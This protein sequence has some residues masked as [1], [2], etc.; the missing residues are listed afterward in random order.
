METL[1]SV[2]CD[3]GSNT[4]ADFDKA[5]ELPTKIP[6]CQVREFLQK[7]LETVSQ[8]TGETDDE[9]ML[10]VEKLSRDLDWQY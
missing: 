2:G 7:E 9:Y 3:M 5:L 6:L 10:R 8:T 1:H 4:D